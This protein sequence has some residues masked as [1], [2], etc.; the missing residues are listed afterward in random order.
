M[1]GKQEMLINV[2]CV[3]AKVLFKSKCSSVGAP[4][5]LLSYCRSVC[6][7]SVRYITAVWLVW[8]CRVN[9]L[10]CSVI[11]KSQWLRKESYSCS[12][13]GIYHTSERMRMLHPYMQSSCKH[14]PCSSLPWDAFGHLF[15]KLFRVTLISDYF[16]AIS[17]FCNV[18]NKF[19][20]SRNHLTCQKFVLHC[21]P[22][23]I[24]PP[25]HYLP[26]H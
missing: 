11:H 13:V 8:S 18:S 14:L 12:T 15:W 4:R 23:Y 26:L 10:H 24:H 17:L 3:D 1:P 19:V 21:C 2:E 6:V 7:C 22:T 9:M 20:L 16:S 25:N 5:L